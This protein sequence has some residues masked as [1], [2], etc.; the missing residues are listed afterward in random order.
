MRARKLRYM[1]WPIG[2]GYKREYRFVG[3]TLWRNYD[4]ARTFRS[5]LRKARRMAR[6]YGP[7]EIERRV[8]GVDGVEVWRVTA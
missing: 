1:I 3:I 2:G 5:A 8:R 6:Q 7:V 4:V